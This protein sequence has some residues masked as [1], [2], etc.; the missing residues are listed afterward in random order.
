VIGTPVGL[1]GNYFDFLHT[2]KLT[3]GEILPTIAPVYDEVEKKILKI[4]QN[5]NS[6]FPRE[7]C[8]KYCN[9]TQFVNEWREYVN[10]T[11]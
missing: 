3:V 8:N 10:A 1:F 11:V 5:Y 2:Y 7:W 4:H 9:Q 6:Y